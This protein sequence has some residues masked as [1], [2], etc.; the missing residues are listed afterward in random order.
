MMICMCVCVFIVKGLSCGRSAR[1]ERQ[2]GDEY[3]V[4]TEWMIQ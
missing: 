1:S 4:S 2:Y 3:M